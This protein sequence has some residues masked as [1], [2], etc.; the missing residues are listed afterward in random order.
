[1]RGPKIVALLGVIATLG[2][3]QCT[4]WDPAVGVRCDQYPAYCTHH[5]DASTEDAGP[6]PDA[7]APV[8]ADA[9]PT[10][11]TISFARDIRPLMNRS[12]TDPAG[13]GCSHCHYKN[14]GT[15]QGIIEGQL[16]MTTLAS[17]RRGGKTSQSRI[18]VPGDPDH[19]AIV[20]KLRGTYPVGARMPWSGPPYWSDAEIQLMATWI[21]QGARGGDDE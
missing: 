8:A 20:Q 15:E 1:M 6:V 18:V 10:G 16:D 13:P 12:E 17:L 19:S 4:A 5:G 11:Q 21:A 2:A 9:A 3:I 14:T 7:S